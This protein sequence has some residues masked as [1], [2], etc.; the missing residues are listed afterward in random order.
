MAGITFEC[1]AG[2]GQMGRRPCVR[3]RR[4]EVS[5][6]DGRILTYTVIAIRQLLLIT[7]RTPLVR[8]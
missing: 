3:E 8:D 4:L 6:L 7:D 5:N 1:E 2:L